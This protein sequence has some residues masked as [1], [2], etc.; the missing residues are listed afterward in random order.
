M[1][2][3][4]RDDGDSVDDDVGSN[5]GGGDDEGDR[6]PDDVADGGIVA[7]GDVAADTDD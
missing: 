2:T 7:H 1:I 4:R 5:N 6:V 3:D